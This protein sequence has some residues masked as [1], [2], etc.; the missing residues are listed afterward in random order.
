[1][2][3]KLSSAGPVYACQ[4][5]SLPLPEATPFLFSLCSLVSI[6]CSLGC[7]P[8]QITHWDLRSSLSAPQ[9]R[10][11]FVSSVFPVLPHRT[12]PLCRF[13][14]PPARHTDILPPLNKGLCFFSQVRIVSFQ[15]RGLLPSRKIRWFEPSF[16]PLSENSFLPSFFLSLF[17]KFFFAQNSP[18]FPR[19][20]GHT[21]SLRQPFRPLLT[22]VPLMKINVVS[23]LL[24]SSL[25][26]KPPSRS[27][28]HSVELFHRE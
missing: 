9:N 15:S 28:L 24:M 17:S 5:G 18:S 14:M 12:P 4:E 23:F 25:G 8:P 22:I 7:R 19:L 26:V 21:L 1:L 6:K 27:R 2:Q 10:S 20:R 16:F 13:F 11:L 3:S